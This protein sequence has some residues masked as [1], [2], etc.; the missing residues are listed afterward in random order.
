MSLTYS[1]TRDINKISNAWTSDGSGD[2]AEETKSVSGVI[3]R[4][5]FIPG[6]GGDQPTA[7]YDVTVLDEDGIDVLAGIGANLA[8]NAD[9]QNVPALGT[10]FKVAVDG[11][12]TFTVAN[13]GA[14]NAGEIHVYLSKRRIMG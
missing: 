14:N 4:V 6:T 11:K 9:T 10:Y 5:V 13:A 8:N 7:A 3:E 1:E 2:S 12:L